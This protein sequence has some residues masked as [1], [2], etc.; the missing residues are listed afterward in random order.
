MNKANRDLV[1]AAGAVLFVNAVLPLFGSVVDIVQSAINAKINR[2][3]LALNLDQCEH[4]AAAE[5]IR[6]HSKQTNAIWFSV[7]DETDYDEMEDDE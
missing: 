4:K 1:I 2:M 3:Q 6:P 7:D 5:V